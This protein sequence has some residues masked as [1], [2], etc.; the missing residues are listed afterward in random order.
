M[1]IAK[2]TLEKSVKIC[3]ISQIQNISKHIYLYFKS[4]ILVSDYG[5]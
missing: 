2:T 5:P 4:R 3:E 1:C